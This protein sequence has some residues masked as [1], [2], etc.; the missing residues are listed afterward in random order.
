MAGAGL[1]DRES[2]LQGNGTRGLNLMRASFTE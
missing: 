1:H 2:I